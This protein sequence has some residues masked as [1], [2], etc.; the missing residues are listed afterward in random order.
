MENKLG[1]LFVC[2][3]NICRSPT[4]EAVFRHKV[5]KAGLSDRLF[6]DSAGTH[7][8]RIGEA[9]D[10]LAQRIAEQGGYDMSELRARQLAR[11]DL[12]QFDYILAMDMKN[13]SALHRLGEP[14]LWQKPKLLMSYSRLYTTKEIVD[15]YG[16]DEEHFELA[17]DMIES[18][19]DGLLAAIRMELP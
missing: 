2:T 10:P 15:P 14:D 16:E 1:V 17:L 9:P 11:I 18:A 8:Y 5:S 6:I 19:S 4:A 7:D 12:E 3:A 13:M